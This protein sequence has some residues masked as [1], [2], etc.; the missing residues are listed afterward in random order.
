MPLFLSCI[1]V[2][3]AKVQ[4]QFYFTSLF[5]FKTK[6]VNNIG[7][8]IGIYVWG[9]NQFFKFLNSDG[10]AKEKWMYF[11]VQRS[12][13]SPSVYF[14]LMVSWLGRESTETIPLYSMSIPGINRVN[15]HENSRSRSH[16]V[17]FGNKL[18]VQR[19][20]E[21]A[22]KYSL[23]RKLLFFWVVNSSLRRLSNTFPLIELTVLI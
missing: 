15:L 17:I 8:S 2:L 4:I 6:S 10:A 7:L 21:M 13:R 19:K 9:C 5:G 11:T 18:I 1:Y 23:S 22:R 12:S 14:Y 20:T 3:S 16:P